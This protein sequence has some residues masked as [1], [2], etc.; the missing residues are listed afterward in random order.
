[1]LRAIAIAILACA[2]CSGRDTG[3][4]PAEPDACACP[5]VADADGLPLCDAIAQTACDPQQK[6]TWIRVAT[7][8]PAGAQGGGPAGTR[9]A[10]E[11]CVFGDAGSVTGYDDC[12]IG[13][14]CIAPLD[15]PRA[16]GTCAAICDTTAAAGTAGACATGS[17][18]AQAGYFQNAGDPTPTVGVCQ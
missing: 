2:A 9:R 3:T 1:M 8:P 17:C 14:V 13:L 18:V 15:T 4:T 12:A 11:T 16:Q 10:G 6:C 5:L 7:Q